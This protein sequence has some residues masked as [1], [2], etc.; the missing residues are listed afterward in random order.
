[1]KGSE[2]ARLVEINMLA[3]AIQKVDAITFDDPAEKTAYLERA[4]K[5]LEKLISE[6]V[7]D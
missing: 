2:Q 5:K 1:M 7:G 6:F 3:E 4:K